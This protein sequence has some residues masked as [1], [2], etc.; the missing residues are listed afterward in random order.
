MELPPDQRLLYDDLAAKIDRQPDTNALIRAMGGV[1]RTLLRRQGDAEFLAA[2]QD[3]FASSLGG[4]TLQEQRQLAREVIHVVI[5]KRPEIAQAWQ[6]LHG[7]SSSPPR[8]RASDVVAPPPSPAVDLGPPYEFSAP[9][10]AVADYVAEVLGR[11]LA[12]FTVPPPA[13]PS[14][15]YCHEQ[16]FFLFAPRFP[17][18]MVAF[19]AGQ[20]LRLSRD[21]LERRIYRHVTPELAASPERL[22]AFLTEKRPELW[23]VFTEKLAGLD[24]RHKSAEAKLAAAENVPADAREPDYKVV[25]VPVSR[26]RTYRILGVEFALGRE[27]AV[28]KVRVRVKSATGLDRE[29]TEALDEIARFRDLAAS[30][31]LDLPPACDFQFLRTLFEF[32]GKKY[33]S[34]VKDMVALAGHEETTSIFL[35]ERLSFVDENFGGELADALSVMLFYTYWNGRFGFQMLYDICVGAGTTR[36]ALISRCPF[37][38]SEVGR[39]PRDLAFQVREALRQRAPERTV[40]EA[41]KMLFSVWRTLAPKYFQPEMDAALAVLA[42]FPVAFAGDPHEPTLSAIGQ[43]VH[44][45]LTVRDMD[46]STCIEGVLAAYTPLRAARS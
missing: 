44:D 28:K 19:A 18:V 27:T 4:R 42:A 8:R 3:A 14:L 31:G 10:R 38:H 7:H 13:F 12:I 39:R 1:L 2:I 20:L 43:Y 17:E 9:E 23:K 16:P 29:E 26:P 24:S 34:I 15:A 36:E 22:K 21:L 40:A 11:R 45:S 30:K 33:S 6:A 5:E 46:I 41:V 35:K 37:L 32:D 25:E